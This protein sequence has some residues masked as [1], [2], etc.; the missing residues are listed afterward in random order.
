MVSVKFINSSMIY[1][2][3]TINGEVKIWSDRKCE[4]L[5]KLNSFNWK[6][7]NII[8]HIQ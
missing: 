1:L 8:N 4:L 3:G 2:T 5:G 7:D 6:P